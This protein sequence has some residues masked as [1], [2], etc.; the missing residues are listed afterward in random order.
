VPPPCLLA[1]LQPLER[2]IPDKFVH[3]I[4]GTAVRVGEALD[5]GELAEP[6]Q[7]SQVGTGDHFCRLAGKAADEDPQ[8]LDH[9]AIGLA[10]PAPRTVQHSL[11]AAVALFDE[12]GRIGPHH[13]PGAS[14]GGQQIARREH[15]DPARGELDRQ[16][17]ALERPADL[18]QDRTVQLS[19]GI[20]GCD[21]GSAVHEQRHR[22]RRFASLVGRRAQGGNTVD[23]LAGSP[24]GT[25]L[26]VITRRSTQSATS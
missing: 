18:S 7:C 25:R 3:L 19:Q 20:S 13:G 6:G 22:I 23:P 16:R 24:S 2:V 11:D 14:Q 17:R 10:Q 15:S 9:R 5:Q 21:A 12:T 26:V 1:E 8:S 4:A